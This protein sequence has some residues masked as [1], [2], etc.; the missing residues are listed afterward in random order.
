MSPTTLK[1][2]LLTLSKVNFVFFF[3]FSFL[4]PYRVFIAGEEEKQHE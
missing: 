2:L 3:L 4:S 1:T